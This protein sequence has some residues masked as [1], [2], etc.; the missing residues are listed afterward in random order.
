MYMSYIYKNKLKTNHLITYYV[1]VQSTDQ[2]FIFRFGEWSD[3]EFF[4]L[5]WQPTL[6]DLNLPTN[7]KYINGDKLQ[8]EPNC[9]AKHL[10]TSRAPFA[11]SVTKILPCVFNSLYASSPSSTPSDLSKTL[12]NVRRVFQG[13]QESGRFERYFLP[14]LLN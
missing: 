4:C 12:E 3:F 14:D 11:F 10:L 6:I 8:G 5:T 7:N 2:P 9:V 1:T 13:K